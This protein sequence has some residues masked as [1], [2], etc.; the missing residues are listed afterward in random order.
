MLGEIEGTIHDVNEHPSLSV[1]RAQDIVSAATDR[2]PRIYRG[3]SPR[4]RP[5][6][7]QPLSHNNRSG[8]TQTAELGG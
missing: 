5:E 6:Q 3:T 4:S 8:A 2:R 7:V 1:E